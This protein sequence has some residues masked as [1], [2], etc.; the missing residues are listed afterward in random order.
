MLKVSASKE[1]G[2]WLSHSNEN[3]NAEQY[4]GELIKV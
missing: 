2:Y 1:C 4:I 3:I